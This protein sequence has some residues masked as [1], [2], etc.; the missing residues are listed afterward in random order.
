MELN[1]VLGANEITERAL[2]SFSEIV[3]LDDEVTSSGTYNK[4]KENENLIIATF[5]LIYMSQIHERW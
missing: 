5:Q 4:F 2:F 3:I 1:S